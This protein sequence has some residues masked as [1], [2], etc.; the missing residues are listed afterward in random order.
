MKKAIYIIAIIIGIVFV[1]TFLQARYE[2]L[3]QP[4]IKGNASGI[5]LV[6]TVCLDDAQAGNSQWILG[7][8]TAAGMFVPE[9]PIEIQDLKILYKRCL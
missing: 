3:Y 6:Y 9:Q 5:R 4:I 8:T 2:K 7:D 1:G